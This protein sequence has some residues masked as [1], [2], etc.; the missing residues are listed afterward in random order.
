MIGIYHRILTPSPKCSFPTYHVWGN[1]N[2]WNHVLNYHPDLVR[3][4]TKIVVKLIAINGKYTTR[5]LST[6]WVGSKWG[7]WRLI[8]SIYDQTHLTYLTNMLNWPNP[9]NIRVEQFGPFNKKLHKNNKM[10]HMCIQVFRFPK[11]KSKTKIFSFQFKWANSKFKILGSV[12]FEN[13]FY[14]L[15]FQS[16]T[17]KFIEEAEVM[18]NGR[19]GKWF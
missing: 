15:R 1:T 5:G 14:V 19:F 11:F 18:E 12:R 7:R 3:V 17:L 10:Y 16:C 9:F 2:Q 6:G 4:Y 8:Q 13:E